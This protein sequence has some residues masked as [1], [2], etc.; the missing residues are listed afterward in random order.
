MEE[1]GVF[2]E[3]VSWELHSVEKSEEGD[4]REEADHRLAIAL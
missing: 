3:L 4:G 1:V 2:A